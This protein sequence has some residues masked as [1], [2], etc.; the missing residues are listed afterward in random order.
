[1]ITAALPCLI[2]AVH[3]FTLSGVIRCGWT[4]RSLLKYPPLFHRNPQGIIR[5]N[6]EKSSRL[7]PLTGFQDGSLAGSDARDFKLI[8]YA[9]HDA[10]VKLPNVKCGILS[11]IFMKQLNRHEIFVPMWRSN[12]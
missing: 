10:K 1:M 2:V 7:W 11:D 6:L 12:I 5:G 4:R 9:I 8:F 3:L